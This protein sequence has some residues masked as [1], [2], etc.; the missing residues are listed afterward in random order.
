MASW[1]QETYSSIFSQ[2]YQLALKKA[3]GHFMNSLTAMKVHTRNNSFS[4]DVCVGLKKRMFHQLMDEH[5]VPKQ[6]QYA[7]KGFSLPYVNEGGR[8]KQRLILYVKSRTERLKYD[9]LVAQESSWTSLNWKGIG[10]FLFSSLLVSAVLFMAVAPVVGKIAAVI[11][12]IIFAT[13][14][15]KDLKPVNFED[16]N[17]AYLIQMLIEVDCL[18]EQGGELAFVHGRNRTIFEGLGQYRRN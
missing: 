16:D 8:I 14:A 5:E 1:I 3:F 17:I 6:K 12:V 9:V 10:L 13:R 15:T 18:L 2:N 4:F 7:S 11:F